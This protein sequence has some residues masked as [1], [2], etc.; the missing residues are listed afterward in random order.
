MLLFCP[1]GLYEAYR[2]CTKGKFF[3]AL[4]VVLATYFS[5]KPLFQ[6]DNLYT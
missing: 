1:I 6:K 2:N 5:S 3:V 4:Y